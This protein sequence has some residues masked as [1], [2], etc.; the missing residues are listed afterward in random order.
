MI[1]VPEPESAA[2]ACLRFHHTS[3]RDFLLG[4]SRAGKFFTEERMAIVDIA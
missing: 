4:P 1:E 3:F 2:G